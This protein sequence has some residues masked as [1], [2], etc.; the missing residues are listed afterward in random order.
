MVFPSMAFEAK[1]V[2]PSSSTRCVVEPLAV[3]PGGQ[4]DLG[5][6]KA[7]RAGQD[8]TNVIARIRKRVAE[9]IKPFIAIVA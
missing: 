5:P 6:L 4:A 8:P 3:V 7:A 2:V 1:N 9:G